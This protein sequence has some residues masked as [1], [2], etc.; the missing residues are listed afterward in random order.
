M[1]RSSSQLCAGT[2][3]R[4]NCENKTVDKDAVVPYIDDE[5]SSFAVVCVGESE[6]GFF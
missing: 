5:F 2:N 6:S 1:L 3:K 4:G